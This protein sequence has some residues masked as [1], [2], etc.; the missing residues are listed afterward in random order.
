MTSPS[1]SEALIS[2]PALKPFE[3]FLGEWQTTGT[4]PHVPGTIFHG[5]ASFGWQYGGAFLIMR[6]QM[7]EAEV[8]SGVAIF[9]SDN[10]A[11]TY[12]MLYFDERGVSRKYDVS[13][14]NNAMTWRRDDRK[15]SQR[16]TIT[17]E[18]SGN[19][20]VGR[21]AMSREGAAWEDDLS[22]TYVRLKSE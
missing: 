13:V 11:K 14:D 6:T 10:E 16:M 21:G 17:V 4:H 5:R 2:N 20:M 18:A 8:P 1:G 19:R 3:A 9:G 22:L 15:F 7:D 12:F